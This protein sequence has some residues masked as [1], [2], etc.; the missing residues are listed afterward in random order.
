MS[1]SWENAVRVEEIPA[2]DRCPVDGVGG[3]VVQTHHVFKPVPP[4]IRRPGKPHECRTAWSEHNRHDVVA[5]DT[6][7]ELGL[8]V[9]TVSAEGG[10]MCLSPSGLDPRD[11]RTRIRCVRAN[12]LQ[13]VPGGGAGT[14]GATALG[15]RSVGVSTR[16]PPG[17]TAPAAASKPPAGRAPAVAAATA[18]A[19]PEQH[20]EV[21]PRSDDEAGHAA[22]PVSDAGDRQAG[23]AGERDVNAVVD[24]DLGP[25]TDR[26]PRQQR[27]PI[28]CVSFDSGSAT[29]P[30]MRP[31]TRP[32]GWGCG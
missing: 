25:A 4:A 16:R 27:R 8:D 3:Q 5:T 6:L 15:A 32:N 11:E 31:C 13:A 24:S 1:S 20:A 23:D 26:A 12:G 14:R 10:Q 28:S 22:P 30:T 18:P 7:A 19:D 2:Q 21:E 9:F 29:R 17:L